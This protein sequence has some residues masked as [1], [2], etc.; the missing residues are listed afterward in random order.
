[1]R[2]C[3]ETG[4]C[5]PS[6]LEACKSKRISDRFFALPGDVTVEALRN[7]VDDSPDRFFVAAQNEFH[8][9][10]YQITHESCDWMPG[11]DL[12]DTVSKAYALDAAVKDDPFLWHQIALQLEIPRGDIQRR[13][14]VPEL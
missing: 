12:M 5:L 6:N 13:E 4:C 7:L 9:T 10:I 3:N 11:G 2:G 14:S 1:M 8:G